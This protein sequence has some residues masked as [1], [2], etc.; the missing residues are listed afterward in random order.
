MDEAFLWMLLLTGGTGLVLLVL[1]ATPLMGILL[2]IHLGVVLALFLAL[3]YGKFVHAAHRLAA[4]IRHAHEQRQAHAPSTAPEEPTAHP[5]V[6]A[7]VP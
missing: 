4:L 3:P 5:G 7:D 6:K 2:A 1:R